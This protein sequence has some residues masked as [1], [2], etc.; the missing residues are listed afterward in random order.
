MNKYL[1][2]SLI[3]AFVYVALAVATYL[4]TD[5]EGFIADY[6]IR[7]G[8][9]CYSSGELAPLCYFI[10]YDFGGAIWY[11]MF[12]GMFVVALA[13]A[14]TGLIAV[15]QALKSHAKWWHVITIYG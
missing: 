2:W 9:A 6:I 15:Y 1:M 7:Y 11:V 14:I 13:S 8:G 4:F 10:I 12:Y 3:L 5:I